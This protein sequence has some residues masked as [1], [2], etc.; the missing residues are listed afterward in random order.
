MKYFILCYTAVFIS[1]SGHITNEERTQIIQEIN[2]KG[3]CL[4]ILNI[5]SN[6]KVSGNIFTFRKFSIR[7]RFQKD[8][9]INI[10][11]NITS[12]QINSTELA[13]EKNSNKDGNIIINHYKSNDTLT[14]QGLLFSTNS[15]ENL[16]L[17]SH[18]LFYRVT[19][20]EDKDT[21]QICSKLEVYENIGLKYLQYTSRSDFEA[22]NEKGR[23]LAD[24]FALRF[25][26]SEIDKAKIIEAIQ[27]DKIDGITYFNKMLN[28][29]QLIYLGIELKN[30]NCNKP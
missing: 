7:V 11:E 22:L 24:K 9:G 29:S 8:C 19:E 2:D 27:L 13:N 23:T 6:Q 26:A 10:S 20:N 15:K 14:I 4:E 30:L 17:G 3:N 25:I 12:S 5:S 28:I 1:C 16:W 18:C 21:A